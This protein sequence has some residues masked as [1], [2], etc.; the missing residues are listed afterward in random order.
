MHHDDDGD[1]SVG[2]LGD[3]NDRPQR[4][5]SRQRSHDH[6]RSGVKQGR[7]IPGGRQET[8]PTCRSIVKSRSSTHT[9]RPQP[10][11]TLIN[12]CRNRGKARIRPSISW[13]RSTSPRSPGR[14]K[15]KIT[16]NC[17]G[18]L[19]VSIARNAKS[20]G[21]A[22]S[23]GGHSSLTFSPA[24]G[25]ALSIPHTHHTE[26]LDGAEESKVIRTHVALLATRAAQRAGETKVL[27]SEN[28]GWLYTYGGP[29]V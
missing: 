15:I 12:R 19:P 18:T 1:C 13:R 17:S 25:Q 16:A 10:G 20:A 8:V 5:I 11:G 29:A 3:Q 22:R 23:M 7:L 27:T 9:E 28:Q 6:R 2:K 14:S 4:M 24:N 21:L 26:W